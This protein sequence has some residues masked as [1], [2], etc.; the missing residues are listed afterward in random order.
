MKR[1]IGLVLIIST[2]LVCSSSFIYADDLTDLHS[3]V[4]YYPGKE[5]IVE[6]SDGLD[7][8]TMQFIADSIAYAGFPQLVNPSHAAL[9][10]NI[11]CTL[12]GHN[13]TTSTVIEVTHNVYTTSPKCVQKTYDVTTCTRSSCDYFEKVL[14]SSKRISSCHG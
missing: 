12:F 11:L 3:M 2:L 5:I 9:P 14:V 10:A 6:N 7:Y 1:I 8:E 4:F 13:L